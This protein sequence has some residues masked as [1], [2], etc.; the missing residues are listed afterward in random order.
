MNAEAKKE[1]EKRVPANEARMVLGADLSQADLSPFA[2]RIGTQ[3]YAME[4]LLEVSKHEGSLLVAAI[5]LDPTEFGELRVAA[6]RKLKS[7]EPE[8]AFLAAKVALLAR[9]NEDVNVEALA[10][11]SKTF[12]KHPQAA[13]L[14]S[15]AAKHHA[16]SYVRREAK[17]SAEDMGVTVGKSVKRLSDLYT[18]DEL[19]L[20]AA[21]HSKDEDKR[22]T[23]A[24]R[25][26]DSSA[27]GHALQVASIVLSLNG[28]P[29]TR[30]RALNLLKQE[31]SWLHAEIC[32]VLKEHTDERVRQLVQG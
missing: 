12:N 8:V 29:R 23:A 17:A 14:V 20:G 6:L 24:L 25:L 5:A 10:Q 32:G 21:L 19:F 31:S 7:G 4:R 22:F 11:L 13:D 30:S 16:N 3:A 27:K 18:R 28:N 26:L 9:G 2:E 1:T 15:W